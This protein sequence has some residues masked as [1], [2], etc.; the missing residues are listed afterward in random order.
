MAKRNAELLHIL[1][2]GP[3]ERAALERHVVDDFADL[4]LAARPLELGLLDGRRF[5]CRAR[6][7]RVRL[8]VRLQLQLQLLV[9]VGVLTGLHITPVHQLQQLVS[10]VALQ[11]A[12]N[13]SVFTLCMHVISTLSCAQCMASVRP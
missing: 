12:L 7:G 3:E 4:A 5:N 8:R 6:R 9:L 11:T 2:E 10:Y 1:E 13:C